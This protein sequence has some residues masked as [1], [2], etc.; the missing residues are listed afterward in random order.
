MSGLPS[1][2][3]KVENNQMSLTYDKLLQLAQGKVDITELFGVKG[4]RLSYRAWRACGQPSR[5]RADRRNPNYVYRFLAR[6]CRARK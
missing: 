6:S 3:S 1:R 4:Q 2:L 5:G